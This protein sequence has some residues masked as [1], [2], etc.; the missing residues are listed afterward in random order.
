[1]EYHLGKPMLR[2]F[3]Q[4][5]LKKGEPPQAETAPV[6]TPYTPGLV[7]ALGIEHRSLVMLLVR[8]GTA[9]RERD[10]AGVQAQLARFKDDLHAH[11]KRESTEL[12]HYLAA[13]LKGE[14]TQSIFREMRHNAALI[15]R[16][17][18]SLLGHYL[19]YPVNERTVLRFEMEL[20]GVIEELSERLEREEAAVY[21][22]YMAPDSY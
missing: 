22:L 1:M 2:T 16:A 3:F 4:K 10:F 20:N 11:Q 15:D 12:H 19:T 5:H 21:T 8:A 13:H 7:S 14:N 18:E 9:A 17:V 6:E